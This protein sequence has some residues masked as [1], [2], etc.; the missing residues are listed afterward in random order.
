ME[1]NN[2]TNSGEKV[3]IKLNRN[4]RRWSKYKKYVFGLIAI[5]V[6]V[7]VVMV[8]LKACDNSDSN[9]KESTTLTTAVQAT[10]QAETTQ[11]V[12]MAPTTT[13]APVTLPTTTEAP[14]NSGVT[15]ISGQ[16]VE[17]EYAA[18][19]KFSSSAFLGDTVMSGVSYYGYASDNQVVSDMNMTSK[20]AG[21]YVDQ[22]LSS[23][24][25]S[26]YIMVG[27]NDLNW[28]TRTDEDVATDIKSTVDIIKS[29]TSAK[30]NVVSI[31]PITSTFESN[32]NIKQTD[33]DGVNSILK[34]DAASQGYI[35]I[36]MANCFKAGGTYMSTDYTNNGV[37]LKSEYYP[38]FLNSL[39]GVK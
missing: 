29:K 2:Q 32:S 34:N 11:P 24:P 13:Q 17:V 4:M 18:D 3:E 31:L 30:I 5:L 16:A 9:S 12:T 22:L 10:T 23:N 21:D 36:D 25:D 27:I 38:F 20:N 1:D 39:A 37:S 7:F 33:I 14:V 15:T 35:F 6:L 19:G 8:V 28:G 26:V